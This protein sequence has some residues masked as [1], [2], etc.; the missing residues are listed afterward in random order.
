LWFYC[1]CV[2]LLGE[3]CRSTQVRYFPEL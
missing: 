2:M 3:G 1:F